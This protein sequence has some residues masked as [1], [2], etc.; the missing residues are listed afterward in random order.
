MITAPAPELVR[1]ER[2]PGQHTPLEPVRPGA[3]LRFVHGPL[4]QPSGRCLGR[5]RVALQVVLKI[6]VVRIVLADHTSAALRAQ[7]LPA[8]P[9][10]VGVPAAPGTGPWRSLAALWGVWS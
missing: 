7:R 8:V 4:V 1:V 9:V 3:Q 2:D 6:V 5:G 10:P